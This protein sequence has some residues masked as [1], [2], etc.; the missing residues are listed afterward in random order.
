M[1]NI[2]ILLMLVLFSCTLV[3]QQTIP[4][5]ADQIKALADQ[6]KVLAVPPPPTPVDCVVTPFTIQSFTP[7][8][9]CVN[10]L[11][12]RT[13]TWARTI[14]TP[15]SN[16]G[17]ACPVLTET[18]SASQ[19]CIMPPPPPTGFVLRNALN[20]GLA[21]AGI[22]EAGLVTTP[23]T[24]Y[25]TSGAVITGKRFTGRVNV[26]GSNITFDGCLF[27]PASGSSLWLVDVTGSGT[28]IKNSTF[29]PQSGSQ[30]IGIIIEGGSLLAQSVNISGFENNISIYGG[31]LTIDQSYIH[32]PS[33]ASNPSGHVDGIEVYGGTNHVF[34]NS[35]I[36]NKSSGSVSP[37]NVAPW[38][39]GASVIGLTIEDNYL[40]GGNA[41]LLVDLQSSGS[42]RFVRVLRNRMGGHSASTFGQYTAFQNA[43]GRGFVQT[44]S[45]LQ[46]SPNSVLWP[47]S[48]SDL[49]V[50]FYT[51]GNPFGYSNLS[52]DRAGQT[53]TP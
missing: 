34:K 20:T 5:L 23:G 48:G 43:D 44:E 13:E 21:G 29:R 42:V 3:A 49:N 36:I 7:W 19:A 22:P 30:F 38:S 52:P 33:N 18:R 40:D 39:G 8:S 31:S 6:I 32:D 45:A 14:S 41:H 25:S 46:A 15:P 26:T 27:N 12:S 53:V 24:T 17:L 2:L 50:W 11:Q 9:T 51:V 47:T 10:S 35:T 37:I 28:V 16:G 1:K 4:S